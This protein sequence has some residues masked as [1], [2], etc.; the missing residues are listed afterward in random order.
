MA[1]STLPVPTL[2][3]SSTGLVPS[4]TCFVAGL[5]W[6]VLLGQNPE[7]MAL[8]E[9]KRARATH[10]V[11]SDKSGN[12]GYTKLKAVDKNTKYVS[13]ARLFAASN[14]SSTVFL[15]LSINEQQTWVCAVSNGSVLTGYDVVTSDHGVVEQLRDA[16]E[17]RFSEALFWGDI[18]GIS[19]E[20]AFNWESLSD[21]L[22][23]PARVSSATLRTLDGGLSSFL[24]SIPKSVIWLVALSVLGVISTKFVVPLAKKYIA[25]REV[26]IV[27]DPDALWLQVLEE[28][29]KAIKVSS[30]GSLQQLANSID[31][32]PTLIEGWRIQNMNCLWTAKAWKCAAKY[33]S[34]SRHQTN[35]AFNSAKP[36]DWTLAWDF[37]NGVTASFDL[38]ATARPISQKTMRSQSYQE[39]TTASQIQAVRPFINDGS[40]PLEKFSPIKIAPPKFAKGEPVPLPVAL[41]LP[42]VA[43]VTLVTPIRTISIMDWTDEVAWKKVSI[44]F[45]IKKIPGKNDSFVMVDLSGEIYAQP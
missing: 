35:A 16:I 6:K 9:S 32:I 26:V 10:Y 29:F 24:A 14:P 21:S 25:S 7:K 19:L 17:K 30:P 1:K 34:S 23:N 18:S 36:A 42:L 38:P 45:N 33:Q 3:D 22:T 8:A 13:M 41:K 28:H 39:L 37:L 20:P 11:Y 2:L 44:S 43:S 12:V 5:S 4:G 31:S 27:E 15:A 40:K